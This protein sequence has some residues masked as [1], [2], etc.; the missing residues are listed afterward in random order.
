MMSD[1]SIGPERIAEQ[2]E[3]MAEVQKIIAEEL[4]EKQKQVLVA[5]RIHGMP[6]DVVAERM[7]TTRNALYKMVHDARLRLKSRLAERGLSAEDVLA[8]FESE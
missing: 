8:S 7:G 2:S 1:P 5:T 3:V 4:T 6:A